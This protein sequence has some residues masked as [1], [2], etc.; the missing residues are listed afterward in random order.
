MTHL[1]KKPGGSQK[2]MEST[3]KS[4]NQTNV[5]VFCIPSTD[6]PTVISIVFYITSDCWSTEFIKVLV[7]IIA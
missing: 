1:Q 5:L 2:F 4:L 6:S 3:E 7:A